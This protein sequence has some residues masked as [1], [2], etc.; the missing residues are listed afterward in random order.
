MLEFLLDYKLL[1][2]KNSSAAGGYAP[3]PLHLGS[4]TS[5][6]P[7]SYSCIHHYTDSD[8]DTCYVISI[9]NQM[10]LSAIN[11]SCTSNSTSQVIAWREAVYTFDCYKYN[12]SL[13]AL[14]CLL[15]I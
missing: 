13:I 6:N 4:T 8:Y 7:L 9:G 3:K 14:K 11:N 12:Y 2:S 15:I 10:H 5:R 1:K